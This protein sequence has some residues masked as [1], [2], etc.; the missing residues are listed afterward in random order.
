MRSLLSTTTFLLP[1]LAVA[2]SAQ[3]TLFEI[4]PSCTTHTWRGSIGVNAG[5]V[6]L[7]IPAS[8]FVGVGHVPQGTGF[9]MT[10]MRIVTQDQ[11]AGTQETY[12]LVLRPDV[13]GTPDCTAPGMLFM[14]GPLQLPP[15][16][17]IQAW[18]MSTTFTTP[19]SLPGCAT[20]YAGVAL[21]A[22]PLWTADGQ[23]IHMAMYATGSNVAANAVNL[24][25]NCGNGGPTQPGPKRTLRIGLL[26]D[27]AVLNMGN[28]DVA[29]TRCMGTNPDLGA[30]GMWPVCE[31]T[32]GTPR[33]DALVA[34]VRDAKFVGDYFQVRMWPTTTCPGFTFW[35]ILHG[36]WYLSPG[37]SGIPIAQGFLTAGEATVTT[38]VTSTFVKSNCALLSLPMY[39]QAFVLQGFTFRLSNRTATVFAAP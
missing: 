23:S 16:T 21:D 19:V 18:V 3:S 24:A 11:D 15:G 7:Q 6:L 32:S 4:Y 36:G 33:N 1:V 26:V 14:G 8:H 13:G 29:G 34:R 31:G 12:R 2:A 39:Y 25:W 9:E 37:I 22:A 35:P 5:E 27:A 28:V 30:G 17:G 38:A 20:Y 10:G